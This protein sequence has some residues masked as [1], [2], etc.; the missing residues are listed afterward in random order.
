MKKYAFYAKAKE[1]HPFW[2]GLMMVDIDGF[3]PPT[4]R[5]SSGCSSS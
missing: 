5:T 2:G 4:F 3:E 1:D